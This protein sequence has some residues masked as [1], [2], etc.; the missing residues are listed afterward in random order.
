MPSSE[1][2]VALQRLK[3]ETLKDILKHV[4]ANCSDNKKEALIKE[5]TNSVLNFGLKTFVF[6]LTEEAIVSTCQLLNVTKATKEELWRVISTLGIHDLIEKAGDELLKHF[7]VTLGLDA[8]SRKDMLNQIED[9]IMLTGM[10]GFLSKLSMNLLQMHC[11]D[12]DLPTSG[13]KGELVDR[14]MV[15][16]FDLEPL[17]TMCSTQNGNGLSKLKEKDRDSE[18]SNK[19]TSKRS[20]R[21]KRNGDEFNKGNEKL[22]K[23]KKKKL[24]SS[25]KATKTTATETSELSEITT[26]STS[27]EDSVGR[28]PSSLK[29]VSKVKERFVAPPLET[30]R[31]GGYDNYVKLYDNFNLPDL[32]RFCKLHELRSHG[33]KKDLIKSIVNFLYQ[34]LSD[35]EQEREQKDKKTEVALPSLEEQKSNKIETTLMTTLT[36]TLTKTTTTTTITTKTNG[37]VATE[38]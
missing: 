10:E 28:S 27:S 6:K 37:S 19:N 21:P 12:M 3:E 11:S 26:N 32:Q 30:I 7:C 14:V 18:R 15:S 24:S 20:S 8:S 9:E 2:E 35:E 33:K 25:P 16:T 34:Q 29:N 23:K 36:T 38:Q 1:I 17:M 13:N 31:I 5:Y 22:D 4:N